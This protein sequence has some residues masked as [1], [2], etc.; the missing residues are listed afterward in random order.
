MKFGL[1]TPSIKKSI[2]ARTT[3]KAKRTLKRLS[4]PFYGKK[5]TGLITNPKKAVYNKVYSKTTVSSKKA[6]G[7]LTACIYYPLYF[8]LLLMW[9][10]VKYTFIGLWFCCVLIINCIIAFV[11]WLINL[12]ANRMTEDSVSGE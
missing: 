1:R 9:Y 5:G 11:E 8:S 3:G 4:N 12:N 7:C 10:M 6:M 2:S